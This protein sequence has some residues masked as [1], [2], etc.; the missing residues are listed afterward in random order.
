MNNINKYR[1]IEDFVQ[2]QSQA[3]ICH[4]GYDSMDTRELEWFRDSCEQIVNTIN[5]ELDF[6]YWGGNT[7]TAKQETKEKCY[8]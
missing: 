5:A 1:F 7:A 4:N 8:D 6:R 2:Y 3:N